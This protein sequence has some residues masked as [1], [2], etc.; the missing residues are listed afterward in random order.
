MG[1]PFRR[2]QNE[3]ENVVSKIMNVTKPQESKK[4][5]II[6]VTQ[7]LDTQARSLDTA[8]KRFEMRDAEIFRKVVRAMENREQA[9]ANI[10]ATELG[11]IRKVEK[12][13]AHASL[14]LQS[15][16]TR[17]STISEVGDLVTVLSP[18]KTVLNDIRSE[19]FNIMPEASQE[20]ENIGGMLSEICS[21][22][23]G[24]YIDNSIG[25]Q[26]ANEEALKILEEAE[27]AAES[28]LKNKLP[29]ISPIYNTNNRRP[30]EA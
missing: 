26:A 13:L 12:M 21:T 2:K 24:Q 10:Y 9:R 14:A 27:V 5:Q 3:K 19:M 1:N 20:L 7:R 16:S 4:E 29:E 15:V 11:E 25:V 6:S 22:T 28:S 18:A 30:L 17:L 23:S 8:V